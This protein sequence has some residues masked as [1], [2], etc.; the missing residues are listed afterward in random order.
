[1]ALYFGCELTKTHSFRLLF[2]D[3]ARW[4]TYHTDQNAMQT[5]VFDTGMQWTSWC[6]ATYMFYHPIHRQV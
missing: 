2:G 3:F 5:T 6:K 1:M 4:E